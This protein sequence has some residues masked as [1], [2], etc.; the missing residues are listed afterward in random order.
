[1][2]PTSTNQQL[3]VKAKKLLHSLDEKPEGIRSSSPAGKVI[4]V[5][6][7]LTLAGIASGYGIAKFRQGET[8][9]QELKS[10]EEA[11]QSGVKIGD[12][13][14]VQDEGTFKDSA[15][16]VL[17]DGGVNGEGSHHLL[18]A[19]GPSQNVYLTSSIVDLNLFTGHKIKVWGETFAAQKAGWLMDVGR[20]KVLEINAV[21]PFTE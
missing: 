18:R 21:P 19:G 1:M 15:E 6:T 14:G 5:L 17:A 13:V 16:G 10:T 20:V 11:A 2:E 4:L 7:L 12:I 9:G 8:I 3:E